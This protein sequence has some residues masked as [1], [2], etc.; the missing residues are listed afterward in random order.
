VSVFCPVEIGRYII[1]DEID[2][3]YITDW[4]DDDVPA[5]QYEQVFLR[6]PDERCS[7][8]NITTIMHTTD[9]KRPIDAIYETTMLMF[10]GAEPCHAAMRFKNVTDTIEPRVWTEMWEML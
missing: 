8:M 1:G 5:P 10:T 7:G 9:Q 4:N 3:R 6:L 2:P